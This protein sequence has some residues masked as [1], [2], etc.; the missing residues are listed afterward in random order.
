MNGL[1]DRRDGQ[2]KEQVDGQERKKKERAG[3]QT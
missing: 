3:G 1:I 2:R